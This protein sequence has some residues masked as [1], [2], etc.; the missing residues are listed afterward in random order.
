MPLLF[1]EANQ[2]L[3][4]ADDP[5][6]SPTSRPRCIMPT[7][8][9]TSLRLQ[10][11][12]DVCD[13]PRPPRG[14][15]LYALEARL[16]P[17]SFTHADVDSDVFTVTSTVGTSADLQAGAHFA[18]NQLIELD[19]SSATW[20]NEFAGASVTVAVST[21]AAKTVDGR[22]NVGWVNTAGDSTT[23]TPGLV[24]LSVQ[25]LGRLGTST[26]APVNAGGTLESDVTGALGAL[27]VKSDVVGAFVNVSGLADGKIGTVTIGGSLLGGPTDGSGQLSASGNMG[28]VTVGHDVRGGGGASSGLITSA[29][30]LAGVTVRGSLLAGTNQDTGEIF[31]S[32]SGANGPIA[33]GHDVRGGPSIRSGLIQVLGVPPSSVASIS[34]GGSLEGGGGDFSGLI[35]CSTVG[36]VVIGHDVRGGT[37]QSGS[38]L[39]NRLGRLTMGGSLLGG[40][41]ID[42]GQIS[43]EF[44][45]GPV[46]IRGEVRGGSG[47]GSGCVVCFQRLSSV[48]IGGSLIGGTAAPIGI[49]GSGEVF[50]G[51]A[52][53]QV[54]V[55][56]SVIG[57]AGEISGIIFSA[58][59]LAGVTIG[60]SLLGGSGN[61]TGEAYAAL[62]IGSV[63]VG[64]DVIGGSIGGTT[65]DLSG[66]G[67]IESAAGRI[68]SVSV[69]GSIVSGI[70][71]STGGG[72]IANASIRAHNDIGTVTVGGS[73]VGN[74]S[75]DG[76]SPVV[77]SARGQAV[78][79]V[80]T[81]VAIGT[82]H[83]GGRVEAAQI[84][85]GYDIDLSPRNADAQIGSLTVGGDWIASSA[86]AGANPGP[87]G[88]GSGD[89]KI[90][91]PGVTDSPGI[92]SRIGSVSIAGEVLGGA[93]GAEFGF[94]AEQVGAFSLG[95]L[96][97]PLS[98]GP[99]NDL[100]PLSIGTTGDVTIHE[101]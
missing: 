42:S 37:G 66:S 75:A 67:F 94:V 86:A 44:D 8:P 72:L 53:G 6:P 69:G 63:R 15:G 71:A 55:G 10:H 33:I 74:L 46:T 54:A 90:S 100:R 61:S 59:K 48:A 22:V 95:G 31:S 81:D 16:A 64:G 17:A 13:T 101:I 34:V 2:R 92:I 83:V 43:S 73:L 70:D 47:T 77:I 76:D 82:L 32:G 51:R 24:S 58:D 14:L 56:G 9:R 89:A 96:A 19:L 23:S 35:S 85:A 41:G 68:A 99:H 28:L 50:A 52:L 38:V 57:G 26:G 40:S 21:F 27:H 36:A 25:S 12:A 49:T 5:A 88:F 93:A 87:D 4:V 97:I 62:D 29:G 11:P 79:G 7:R 3:I 98:P 39:C 45:A 91:G 84:L 30:L 1:V 80:T 18:G 20:G 78:P 65:G 60:G